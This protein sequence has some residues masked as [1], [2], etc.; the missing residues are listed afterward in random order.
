M[1]NISYNQY[2]FP[3]TDDFSGAATALRRLQDT[4]KLSTSL[5]S[6]GKLGST[7]AVAMTCEGVGGEGIE[8]EGEGSEG[9]GEGSEGEGEGSEGGG[10]G[11]EGGGEGSEGEGEG[12]EGGGEGSEGEGEGSE[13]GREGS[14]GEGE[15]SEG[16][17]EGSEGE[18][19]GSEGGGEGSEGEEALHFWPMATDCCGDS[20]CLC[21]GCGIEPCDQPV[22]V[23]VVTA[24]VS[25]HCH[26]VSSDSTQKTVSCVLLSCCPAVLLSC[27]PLLPLPSPPSPFP[28]AED[29]FQVGRDAYNAKDWAH[30]RDW[31]KEA[32]RHVMR[33]GRGGGGGEVGRG[34]EGEGG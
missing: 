13:G 32:L 18:G 7:M 4:Y 9:G 1:A 20:F 17:G 12:S 22:Q 19:E 3:T 25:L 28:P 15:G 6:S 5:I 23:P 10:E 8:G 29:C 2:R 21:G 11:S 34:K 31:M 30:T 33:R 26:A 24:T 27:S 14:E 16:G